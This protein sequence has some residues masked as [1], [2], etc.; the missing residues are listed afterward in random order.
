MIIIDR[1]EGEFAVCEEDGV[2]KDIPI[3]SVDSCAKEGDVLVFCNGAY[4][5]DSN[6]TEE[7]KKR[8]VALFEKF[9]KMKGI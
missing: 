3:A 4:V 8:A 2:M 1:F 7:R 6:K 9:K 5:I